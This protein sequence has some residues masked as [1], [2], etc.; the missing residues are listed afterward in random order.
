MTASGRKRGVDWY[1]WP[2]GTSAGR[3]VWIDVL[4]ADR[5]TLEAV[6]HRV[7][8]PPELITYCLLAERRPKVVPC[9]TW[10]YSAW[11]IPLC[12]TRAPTSGDAASVR[13]IEVKACLGPSVVV[14]TRGG[15]PRKTAVLARLLPNGGTLVRERAAN[16]LVTLLERVSAAHVA[17][18]QQLTISWVDAPGYA[19]SM[20]QTPR[21]AAETRLL[22]HVALHREALEK[23]IARGRRWLDAGEIERLR[24]LMRQLATLGGGPSPLDEGPEAA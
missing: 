2:C 17:A 24:L 13:L 6:G 7:G 22:R 19:P 5:Q 23:L 12:T 14:T 21:T 9:G 15:G 1:S 4:T 18:H 10:L 20:G 16:L 11:Q 3:P 8:L